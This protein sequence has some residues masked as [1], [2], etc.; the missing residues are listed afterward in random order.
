MVCIYTEI[1]KELDAGHI[2]GLSGTPSWAA[3]RLVVAPNERVMEVLAKASDNDVLR[4]LDN[5]KGRE[6]ASLL[7]NIPDERLLVLASRSDS[8]IDR[9]IRL[10]IQDR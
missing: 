9:I 4:F 10:L 5:F 6:L 7:S 3:L 2:I 8:R 1:A